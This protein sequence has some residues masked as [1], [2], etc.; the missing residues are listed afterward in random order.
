[1]HHLQNEMHQEVVDGSMW[2]ESTTEWVVSWT[3]E[4]F[5]GYIPFEA[6]LPLGKPCHAWRRDEPS[7]RWDI[8]PHGHHMTLRWGVPHADRRACG[9]MIAWCELQLL[10][11]DGLQIV[12]QTKRRMRYLQFESGPNT[13]HILASKNPPAHGMLQPKFRGCSFHLSISCY[14]DVLYL[15]Y[16]VYDGLCAYRM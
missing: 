15:I 11:P 16:L 10:V 8:M 1:M 5:F 3:R 7:L 6:C 4:R 9:I 2:C 12:Y 14:H 13:S